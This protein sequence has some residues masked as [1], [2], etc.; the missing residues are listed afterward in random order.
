MW[1]NEPGQRKIYRRGARDAF[2]SMIAGLKAPE[3]RAME[4]WLHDLDAWH[5]GPPPPPPHAW[6]DVGVAQDKYTGT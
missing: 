6:P 5:E 2:D 4:D 3:A 1:F